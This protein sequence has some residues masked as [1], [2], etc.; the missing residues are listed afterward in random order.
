MPLVGPPRR[1]QDQGMTNP[2]T[3]RVGLL[4]TGGPTA[5]IELGG[6]RLLT[7]PTFDAPRDYV[8]SSG[9]KLTKTRPA[10]LGVR[11]LGR[12]DAVLL[13]HD[14]HP[15]NLD[16]AGRALLAEV[17]RV[18]TTAAGAARLAERGDAA[19]AEG[20]APW[21]GTQLARP[22]GGVLTVTAVPALHGPEGFE[23]R[24]GPVI[25]FVLAA[26]DLPTVYVSGDNASLGLVAEIAERFGPVDT[27]VLFAGAACAPEVYGPDALLT[28]DSAQAAEAARLL[29]ARRAVVLHCDS[30]AHFSEDFAEVEK[31]FAAAGLADR[32]SPTRHGSAYEL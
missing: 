12:I 4:S 5:L 15:D 25:G 14:Q 8:S 6:L 9:A 18:L 30:W 13:S 29:G 24:T 20:L 21:D 27:A 1:C 16:G 26:Q 31:A 3:P 17:P 22:D 28:L 10:A 2:L 23:E 11:A 7:D 19:H 32:L